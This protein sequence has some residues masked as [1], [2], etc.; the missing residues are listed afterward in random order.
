MNVYAIKAH[1]TYGGGMSVVAAYSVAEAKAIAE[2]A[3]DSMWNVR[4]DKPESVDLLP[5]A[6]EGPPRVLAHYETGE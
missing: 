2:K 3:E 6:C 5:L 4:Y 1:G